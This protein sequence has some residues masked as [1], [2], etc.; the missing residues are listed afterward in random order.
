MNKVKQKTKVFVMFL[1]ILICQSYLLYSLEWGDVNTDGSVDIVDALLVA[2]YY[3][4][5][6]PQNF[7]ES[8]A[9]V[10]GNG[11]I[12]IVDAL[13]IAQFYVGLIT[14]FPVS[15]S[16]TPEPTPV[17]GT[18]PVQPFSLSQV[19]LSNSPFTENRDRTLS[20]LR[21]LDTDRL[22]YNF[23]VAAG[24]PNLGVQAPGGWEAPDVKLRGHSTGHFLKA[25]SQAYAGTG[26]P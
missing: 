15:S 17:S 9:D 18:L 20:Y 14:E 11:S 4:G 16:Q 25:L 3:V 2:Q 7:S 10:S 19:S 6:N 26:D 1:F 12:E 13:L 8:N 24:L 23:R 22:L 5:L 21:F